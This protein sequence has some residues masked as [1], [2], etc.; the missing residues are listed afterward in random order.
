MVRDPQRWLHSHRQFIYRIIRGLTEVIHFLSIRPP[1]KRLA[2][3]G[4]KQPE[5]D[6]I[7]SVNR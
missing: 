2:D 3:V 7:Q 6:I 1:V 5:L 4:T